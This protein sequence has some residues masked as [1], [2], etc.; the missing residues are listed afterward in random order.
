MYSKIMF[1]LLLITVYYP[2]RRWDPFDTDINKNIIKGNCMLSKGRPFKFNQPYTV[3]SLIFLFCF[4]NV[5]FSI[6][7]LAGLMTGDWPIKRFL[8]LWTAFWIPQCFCLVCF[9]LKFSCVYSVFYK[10]VIT[11]T[12][13]IYIHLRFSN[14]LYLCFYYFV[15]TQLAALT[16][17]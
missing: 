4:D 17:N 5:T 8:L 9:V 10:T 12:V 15:K 7:I 2:S 14:I 13:S 6:D 11:H 16:R 1:Q 3:I